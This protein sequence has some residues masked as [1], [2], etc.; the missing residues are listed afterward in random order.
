MYIPN[1][2]VHPL[3]YPHPERLVV[4]QENLPGHNLREIA[5][6]PEDFAEFRSRADVFSA[7]AGIINN[8]V[9]LTGSGSPDIPMGHA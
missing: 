8:D 4:L 1:A 9:T 7:M 5:P 6:S 2:Q 3:P